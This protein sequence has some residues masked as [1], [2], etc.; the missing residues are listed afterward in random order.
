MAFTFIA[1]AEMAG[2]LGRLGQ[3]V[4]LFA[5][6]RRCAAEQVVARGLKL[7]ARELQNGWVASFAIVGEA[8]C[9]SWC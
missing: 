6:L 3:V 2:A 1:N 8:S 4:A 5:L 7:A 9:F